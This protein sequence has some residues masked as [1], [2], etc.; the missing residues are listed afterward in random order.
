MFLHEAPARYSG[1]KKRRDYVLYKNVS[2]GRPKNLI[3]LLFA[4]KD[5]LEGRS[6]YLSADIDEAEW[7]AY[8]D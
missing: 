3:S 5:T 7:T 4:R 8:Y 2:V 6:R 1:V